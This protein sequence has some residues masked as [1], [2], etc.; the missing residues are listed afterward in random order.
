MFRGVRESTMLSIK[1][2]SESKRSHLYYAKYCEEQGEQ[3]GQ[4]I[5]DGAEEIGLKGKRVDAEQMRQL[6]RGFDQNGTALCKNAGDD[7]RGG[8]D[9]TFSAPKSFSIVWSTADEQLRGELETALRRSAEKAFQFMQDYAGYVRTGTG[10]ANTEKAD[11]VGAMFLHSSNRAGEPQAHVHV[12]AMNAAKTQSDQ[13][14]RTMDGQYFYKA[15]M[16]GGSMFKVALADEVQRLGF[17]IDQGKDSFRI[18]GVPKDVCDAQSSR[19]KQ[20]E[21]ELAQMGL[22]RDTA[23][24]AVIERITLNTRDK[25]SEE[26]R[27]DF[28]RWQR[29]NAALGF[30]S[31]DLSAIRV[32]EAVNQ[33]LDRDGQYRLHRDATGKITEQRST[34][35]IYEMAQNIAEMSIGRQDFRSTLDTL[36]QARKDR[37]TIGLG[38]IQGQIERYTTAEMFKLEKELVDLAVSRRTEGLHSVSQSVVKSV[39]SQPQYQSIRDEQRAAAEHMTISQAGVS[40]LRGFAGAGKTYTLKVTKEIFEAGGFT[41]SGIAPTNRAAAGLKKELGVETQ[42]IHSFLLAVEEGRKAIGSRDVILVDEGAMPDSRLI[43]RLNK[44]AKDSNSKIIFIGDERQIQPIQAGQA[45]GTLFQKLGGAELKEVYRQVRVEE[46]NAILAVRKGNI[47]ETLKYYEGRNTVTADHSS[48]ASLSKSW[49]EI[50]SRENTGD[51]KGVLSV[52]SQHLDDVHS[53]IRNL[54]KQAGELHKEVVYPLDSK[55]SIAIAAGDRI[56]FT[57]TDR[58]VGYSK[59]EIAEVQEATAGWIRLRSEGGKDLLVNASR[60]SHLSYGYAISS[61]DAELEKGLHLAES[62]SAAKTHLV[63]DWLKAKAENAGHSLLMVTT[64]NGMAADL[65]LEVRSHLRAEGR[66]QDSIQVKMGKNNYI[67]VA[68]GDRLI[69]DDNWKRNGI[70]RSDLSTVESVSQGKISVV[71]DSGSR[72]EF[73]PKQFKGFKHGYAVTAHKSQGV[74]VDRV[75]LL[76]DSHHIDREKFYVGISRGREFAQIYANKEAITLGDEALSRVQTLTGKDKLRIL[77]QE[78]KTA[79]AMNLKRSG[80]KDTSQDYGVSVADDILSGVKLERSKRDRVAQALDELKGLAKSVAERF[81]KE[82]ERAS[83]A[84][85]AER[86]PSPGISFRV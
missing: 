31:A 13:V 62:L 56:R 27:R 10:G 71:T 6:L 23:H 74:T 65:N 49:F 72:V 82:P 37:H 57:A 12:V 69:F 64:T 48:S 76:L 14:W 50:L 77:E 45:F 68:V 30:D 16:A 1:T 22:T 66:L 18:R 21:A 24:S 38:T 4:W 32:Q 79:L 7:H 78:F 83:P 33:K 81:T 41:V 36:S 58:E 63:S 55:K 26:S 47:E 59:G 25:K 3:P 70:Y 84:P 86:K 46:A 85:E 44:L 19:S 43:F 11:M 54:R 61:R 28:D 15:K 34:F 20:I 51:R 8:W 42:S 39:M 9:F 29:E 75:F 5:G 80:L 53:F 2:I 73:D 60:A 67:E 35:S 17:E 40:M 52:D